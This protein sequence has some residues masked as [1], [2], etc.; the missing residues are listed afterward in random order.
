MVGRGVLIPLFFK[1]PPPLYCLPHLFFNFCPTPPALFF[2][3]CCFF[4]WIG[5]HT[6]FDELFYL[7]I[8]WI[9]T[10]QALVSEGPSFVFYATSVKFTEVWHIIW[11]FTGTLVWYH[12]YTSTQTHIAHTETSR[13]T[14][15]YKYI[16]T[17]TVMCSQWLP[18]LH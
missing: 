8:T 12:T 18:L 16:F 14:H 9:Y 7:M 1:I 5:D 10:C 15:P 11:F 17:L 4:G 2:L 13:L 6:T 3:L